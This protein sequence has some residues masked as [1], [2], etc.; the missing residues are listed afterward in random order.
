[1]EMTNSTH[2]WHRRQD[3]N[4]GH[5]GEGEYSQNFTKIEFACPHLS[6][7][8]PDSLQYPGLPREYWQQSAHCKVHK[9]CILL[10][11]ERTWERGCH[12]EYS[13]YGKELGL[14]LLHHRIKKY[15]DLA[16]T[17]F[18]TDGAFKHFHSGEWICMPD[19]PNTC[20]WKL[21]P[22]GKT[23]RFKNILTHQGP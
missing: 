7:T 4:P 17:Q 21:Y 19:S 15:L 2:I 11:L 3:L 22:K 18:R 20:G 9:I 16:Y 1:M 6:D 23:C 10:C 13:I 8:Y 5:T 14:I 12:L